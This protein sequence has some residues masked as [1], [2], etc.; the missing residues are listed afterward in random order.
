MNTYAS[1]FLLTLISVTLLSRDGYPQ[2]GPFYA[3]SSGSLLVSPERG[4]CVVEAHQGIRINVSRYRKNLQGHHYMELLRDG[5]QRHVIEKN[6]IVLVNRKLSVDANSSKRQ[7]KRVC[8]QNRK[9]DRVNGKRVAWVASDLNRFYNGNDGTGTRN[10]LGQKTFFR[11]NIYK[12]AVADTRG[13]TIGEGQALTLCNGLIVQNEGSTN[14]VPAAVFTTRRNRGIHASGSGNL[15]DKISEIA[16][17]GSYAHELGHAFGLADCYH[18]SWDQGSGIMGSP[19][20]PITAWEVDR[21][22]AATLEAD[23]AE[24]ADERTFLLP[25]SS[26]LLSQGNLV[27]LSND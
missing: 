14:L 9:V 5:S 26:V 25:C 19:P 1:Y 15:I 24:P 2:D 13:G 21:I 3:I 20:K 16:P 17:P 6:V 18:K 12:V 27:N 7:T 8:K 10:S 23:D 22:L 11:F 4:T